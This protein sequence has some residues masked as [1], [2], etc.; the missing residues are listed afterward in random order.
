MLKR[1]ND[2]KCNS[3]EHYGG[4]GI[5]VC[6]EWKT[7]SNF[8]RDLGVRPEGKTLDRIDVNGNYAPGNCKWSSPKEQAQNKRK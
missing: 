4:R 5:S 3:F 7:F 8:L 1:C 6:D 2:P